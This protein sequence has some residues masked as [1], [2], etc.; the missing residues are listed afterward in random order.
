MY[1]RST[2]VSFSWCICLVHLLIVWFT[3]S[4]NSGVFMF[5]P[6]VSVNVQPKI[7]WLQKMILGL[8]CFLVILIYIACDAFFIGF[9]SV[10]TQSVT[11]PFS[12]VHE[13]F[14]FFSACTVIGS[15]KLLSDVKEFL[16]MFLFV[17][18]VTTIISSGPIGVQY[19]RIR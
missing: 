16:F 2:I 7:V 15:S 1:L 14:R 9:Y 10:L 8:L 6:K 11:S 4:T 18:R 12:L 19:T 5:F 13:E 17:P 3:F